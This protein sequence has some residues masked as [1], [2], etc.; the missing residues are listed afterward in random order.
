M[1]Q[2][3]S[4]TYRN[5]AGGNLLDLTRGPAGSPAPLEEPARGCH[6]WR[7]SFRSNARS[8]SP[9]LIDSGSSPATSRSLPTPARW[10]EPWAAELAPLNPKAGYQRPGSGGIIDDTGV[11]DRMPRMMQGTANAPGSLGVLI[12]RAGADRYRGTPGAT[13]LFDPGLPEP[14][15][16]QHHGSQ[17]FGGDSATGYFHDSAR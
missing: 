2:G 14:V 3:G 8:A 13:Q 5:N 16:T 15:R 10:P 7:W 17:G 1:D 11:C 12:D 4:D 6:S 9:S